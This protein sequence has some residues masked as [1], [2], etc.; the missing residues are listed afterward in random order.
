[1]KK[2]ILSAA[3]VVA[4]LSFTTNANAQSDAKQPKSKKITRVV[5]R[6]QATELQTKKNVERTID[7]TTA[8]SPAQA[9]EKKCEGCKEGNGQCKKA[10]QAVEKKECCK[11]QAQNA[12]GKKNCNG[13]KAGNG[14]CKKAAQAV[15]KKECCKEKAQNAEVKKN[16]N[17]C[18]EGNGQCKKAAQAAEKKECCK[19]KAQK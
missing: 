15:E 10:A 19:E 17:G 7:A 12:E 14:Q 6:N 4:A 13:C 16:C 5:K 9:T 3:L 8:A 2:L 1:M 18:K 11:E